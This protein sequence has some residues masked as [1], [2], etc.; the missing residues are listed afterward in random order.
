MSLENLM[1][2]NGSIIEL[3]FGSIENYRKTS[4]NFRDEDQLSIKE[5]LKTGD[6]GM[7]EKGNRAVNLFWEILI[8]ILAQG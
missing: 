4:A 5:I 2:V 8:S 3:V 6:G 7:G 1:V